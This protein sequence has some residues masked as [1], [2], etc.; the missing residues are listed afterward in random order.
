[1][2][3]FILRRLASLIPILLGVTFLSFLIINLT[4]GDFLTTMSMDPQVSR[5]RIEQLRHNFGLDQPWYVQYGL[6]V[7]RLS[8]FEYPLGLKWPDLGYSFRNKTPV[9]QVMS[10]RLWNSLVLTGTAEFFIWL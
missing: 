1:M 5:E 10:G 4:P 7:Y 6:W 8:P 9:L 3:M 2:K